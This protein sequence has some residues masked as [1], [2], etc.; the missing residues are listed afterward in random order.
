M[1]GEKNSS[2]IVKNSIKE[3]SSF[4]GGHGKLIIGVSEKAET[5]QFQ[6]EIRNRLK[7]SA[8]LNQRGFVV[9]IPARLSQ[10]HLN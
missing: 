6:S 1:P 5:V 7:I 9:S 4:F 8:V 10:L 2:K 3:I